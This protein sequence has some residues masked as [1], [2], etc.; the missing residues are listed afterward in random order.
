MRRPSLKM[1]RSH[2]QKDFHVWNGPR[3]WFWFVP[4]DQVGAIGTALT[5]AD[6]IREACAV[7]EAMALR[8]KSNKIGDRVQ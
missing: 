1:L 8:P 3:N 6:A 7:I 2:K 4:Y 5:Q